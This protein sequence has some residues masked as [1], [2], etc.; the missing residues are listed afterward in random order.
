M[1]NQYSN[2]YRAI[3][4]LVFLSLMTSSLLAQT[5]FVSTTGTNSNPASATSWATS[6][7]NLQ[8]AIDASSSGD[9]VWVAA[10][11]YK[12]T[13]TT[14]PASRTISFKMKNEVTVYGGFVGSETALSGRPVIDPVNGQPSNTTL[15]GDIGTVG[16]RGDNSYHVI[17]NP[18]GLDETAVLDGFV[19]TGGNASAGSFPN[20]AGG[21]V[22]NDGGGVENFCNPTFRNCS[23]VGNSAYRGG[24]MDNYGRTSGESSPALT[25][26][27][28]QNNTATF[29]GAMYNH[30]S[31]DAVSSPTLTNCLIQ[32]NLALDD[33]GAFYNNGSNTG[34]S[35][36]ALTNCRILNNSTPGSGGAMYNDGEESGVSNPQFRGCTLQN[37]R[38][39][40]G[41]ALYNDGSPTGTSSPDL[42]RCTLQSNSAIYGGAIYS[43]A[44]TT[45]VSGPTLTNCVLQSNSATTSGGA[46]YNNGSSSGNSSL[47]L[48]NCAFQSNVASF[49]GGLY[50]DGSPSGTSSPTLVNCSFQGNAASTEGGAMLNNGSGGGTSHPQ[51]ANCVLFGNGNTF[52]NN[53]GT[54]TANYSLFEP[55]AVTITGVNVSGPGNLTTTTSPFFSATSVALNTC[56]PAINAGN[57]ASTTTNEGPYSVTDLPKT[58]VFGNAR[59]IGRVDMGAAEFQGV[60]GPVLSFTLLGSGTATCA[61]SPTLTLSGSETAVSYQLWRNESS[62]GN[63][64]T[65]TGAALSFGP[66]SLSG[67]YTV[68]ATNTISSCSAMM[69]GSATVVSGGT[70]PVVQLTY[71]NGGKL[72][73][74]TGGGTYFFVQVLD[75]VGN[76]EIRETVESPDG[77]FTLKRSG[78]FWVI[79]TGPD[80]CQTRVD[81]V[82]P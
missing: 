42:T 80:G 81:G 20:D 54:V 4:L 13:T 21:G 73:R 29:G 75:R 58:D 40:R 7:T 35:S 34:E 19:I 72:L 9:A 62:V 55:S 11:A 67:T 51:L 39:E 68:L 66:Q 41:G 52:F 28:L 45:G 37:N 71:L 60:G 43:N 65:G 23:L 78:P 15:S 63:A 1:L 8:G 46:L 50:N 12:P 59:L 49:G 69:A 30:G 57:P 82:A 38:A 14:G 18:V 17:K 16:N 61:A 64:V 2:R 26:C 24:G 3:G 74:V 48:V 31:H 33:G 70:A 77:F 36:P 32:N 10:G 25:N 5:R 53:N 27:V 44:S 79:V 76:Y 6:T 56:S 47:Q 22:L